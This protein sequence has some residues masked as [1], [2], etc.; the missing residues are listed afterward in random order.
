MIC[1]IMK[2]KADVVHFDLAYVQA[3]PNESDYGLFA[4]DSATELVHGCDPVLCHFD[5][6]GVQQHLEKCH[7]SRFP[8]SKKRRIALGSKIK[9]SI[10]EDTFNNS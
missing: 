8:C 10:R 5:T 6:S 9:R 1:S 2:P 4:I 3:Q 7:L